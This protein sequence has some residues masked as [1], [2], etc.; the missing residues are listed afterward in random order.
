[1]TAKSETVGVVAYESAYPGSMYRGDDGRYVERD[2]T[3]SL[4]GSLLELIATLRRELE[5]AQ[6]AL[7]QRDEAEAKLN[8]LRS[9]LEALAGEIESVAGH[10]C[11]TA[12]ENWGRTIRALIPAAAN[13]ESEETR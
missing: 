3:I 10:A 13:T 1:M 6:G 11:A 2:D 5:D 12:Q 4:A 8:T 7:L 9:G